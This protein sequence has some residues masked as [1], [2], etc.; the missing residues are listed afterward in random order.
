VFL[1]FLGVDG[2]PP[3]DLYSVFRSFHLCS[4]FI[5]RWLEAPPP[6]NSGKYASFSPSL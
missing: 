2:L 4:V 6:S 1:K 5:V 3:C